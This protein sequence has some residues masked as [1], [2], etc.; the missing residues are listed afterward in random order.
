MA[1]VLLLTFLWGMV[2]VR[3]Y[4]CGVKGFCGDAPVVVPEEQTPAPEI[5]PEEE[6]AEETD[7]TDPTYWIKA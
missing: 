3:W 4:T 7:Y 2:S 1:V 6:P 5:V